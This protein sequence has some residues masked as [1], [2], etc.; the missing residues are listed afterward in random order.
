MPT[1]RRESG[2]FGAGHRQQVTQK[3]AP[4]RSLPFAREFDADARAPQPEREGAQWVGAWPAHRGALTPR[5]A[6]SRLTLKTSMKTV[7]WGIQSGPFPSR[8]TMR[9]G[10]RIDPRAEFTVPGGGP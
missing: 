7:A 3:E 8:H 10:R 6:V 2:N 1:L 5:R 9:V 4:T